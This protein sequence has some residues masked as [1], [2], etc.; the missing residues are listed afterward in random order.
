MFKNSFFDSQKLTVLNFIACL[1]PVQAI[2]VATKNDKFESPQIIPVK[3]GLSGRKKRRFSIYTVS[4]QLLRC[5]LDSS[6][7]LSTIHGGSAT[8]HHG[9]AMNAR[10]ASTIR[11]G[12]STDQ[13]GSA[14]STPP[15]V[16]VM[17]R[18]RSG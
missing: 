4:N 11:Y 1:F 12:A 6:T 8:I 16:C 18:S 9:G 17:I 3:S 7:Y 15:T 14:K 10:D 13:A 2:Q 5:L